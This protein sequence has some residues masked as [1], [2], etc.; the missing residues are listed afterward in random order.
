MSYN[1]AVVM[2]GRDR[3]TLA[4]FANRYV[5]SYLTEQGQ[6]MIYTA[7]LEVASQR[8]ASQ[9]SK[10]VEEVLEDQTLRNKV[11]GRYFYNLKEKV[12]KGFSYISV[13][14]NLIFVH[15][16]RLLDLTPR[17]Y[18]RIAIV[19]RD[20]NDE[21][22]LKSMPTVQEGFDEVWIVEEDENEYTFVQGGWEEG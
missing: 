13:E 3:E 15:R 8:L 18:L 19:V 2:V 22:P 1:V 11:A 9:L 7:S 5:R 14:K 20:K 4:F 16:Q 17:D 12:K 21:E 10:T 6:S